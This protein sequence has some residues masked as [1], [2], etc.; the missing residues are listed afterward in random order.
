MAA[1]AL[2]A[3]ACEP[4]GDR[5]AA[6]PLTLD[7]QEI[8]LPAPPAGERVMVRALAVCGGHWY[9]TG[10]FARGDDTRPAAWSSTDGRAWTAMTL[11]PE[12]YYGHRSLVY[13]AACRDGRLAGVGGRPGG[14]HGNPRVSSWYLAPGPDGDVLTEAPAHFE[15]YGGPAAVNVGRLTSGP[16]GWL[17]TGNRASGAAVWLSQDA[18]EFR[19]L[20]GAPGLRTEPGHVTW[21]SH[22]VARD[23]GWTVVGG[24]IRAGRIDRDA[25]A[26]TSAD[27][28]TW[29]AQTVPAAGDYDEMTLVVQHGTEL[30]A[31]GPNGKTF[32]A[33][34]ATG[35]TWQLAGRF[36]STQPEGTAGAAAGAAPAAAG[37]ASAG[38][39]VVAVAS[40]GVTFRL[41]ATADGGAHWRDVVAPAPLAAGT[42]R[43]VTVTAVKGAAGAPD[44]LLLAVDDGATSRLFLASAPQ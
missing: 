35:D 17:I 9:A 31:I 12:S 13:T 1:V 38:S 15:L 7:W 4:D 36:G 3:G 18:T 26:W 14:A 23:D 34:R 29:R 32:Q 2:A 30:V 41:W 27:G 37:L 44:R 28:T 43:A 24:V 10:A 33:W 42:H 21:A 22:A 11:A 5:P 19:I 39:F 40:D 25:A 16:A 20:E 6:E 8:N